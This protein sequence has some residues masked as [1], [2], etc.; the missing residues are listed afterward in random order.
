MMATTEQG[1]QQTQSAKGTHEQRSGVILGQLMQAL[2]RPTALY[3]VEVRHLWDNHFRANVFV[4]A[5]A[6]S[7]RIAH[8]FFLR[9]D[10]EGNIVTSL[11][12]IS[13]KY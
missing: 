6:T 10:E 11:P 12:D 9:A 5:T 2:G 8:S 3:R 7:T 1:N 13:R 4:G